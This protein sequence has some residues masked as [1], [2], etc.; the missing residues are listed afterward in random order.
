MGSASADQA[1][2][3]PATFTDEPPP[4][5]VK[6]TPSPLAAGAGAPVAVAEDAAGAGVIGASI[7]L[8]RPSARREAPVFGVALAPSGATNA[9]AGTVAS[10]AGLPEPAHPDARSGPTRASMK[11][12]VLIDPPRAPARA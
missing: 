11:Q 8:P 3:S 7:P 1:L 4:V 5:Q 9:A 10:T 6:V 12:D 2:K